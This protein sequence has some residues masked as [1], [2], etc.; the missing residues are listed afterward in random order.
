MADLTW[1]K[2]SF[3]ESANCAVVALEPDRAHLADSKLGDRSPV[4]SVGAPA[5]HAFLEAVKNGELRP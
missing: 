5:W 4:I 1:R 2:S 3:C